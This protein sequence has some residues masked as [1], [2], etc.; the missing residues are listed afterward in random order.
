MSQNRRDIWNSNDW[1]G[2]RSLNKLLRKRTLN[3]LAKLP[4]LDLLKWSSVR[5]RMVVALNPVAVTNIKSLSL[6]FKPKYI[7][8]TI[9]SNKSYNIKM[10]MSNAK[11]R[12]NLP[13]TPSAFTPVVSIIRTKLRVSDSWNKNIF[14]QQ[15]GNARINAITKTEILLNFLPVAFAEKEWSVNHG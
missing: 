3:H 8:T 7:P 1:N 13:C 15:S 6:T 11:E 14:I 12:M 4:S 5:L 2:I 10:E 9:I